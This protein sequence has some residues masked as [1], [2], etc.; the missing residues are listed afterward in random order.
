MVTRG[1]IYIFI[2]STKKCAQHIVGVQ[3]KYVEC[4]FTCYALMPKHG[5]GRE[6]LNR[7]IKFSPTPA[8][9]KAYKRN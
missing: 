7:Q 3:E 1:F 6:I 8:R 5:G 9:W 2:P 4:L